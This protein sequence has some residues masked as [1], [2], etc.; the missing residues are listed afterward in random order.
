MIL[1]GMPG[2]VEK[3]YP[4]HKL[5]TW[6]IGGP[7]EAVYWPPTKEDLS[8]VWQRAQEAEVPVWLIGQ[9]SNLLLPDEGLPGVTL[10]TTSLRAIEWGDYTV[11]VEAGYLLARL[12]QEAGERGFSGLESPDPLV[13]QS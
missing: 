2:R 4:L 1:D 7:A 12:A 3:N 9:G 11:Q 10:V 6:K 5:T 8:T 13:V